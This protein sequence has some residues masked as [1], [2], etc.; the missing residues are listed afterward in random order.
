MFVEQFFEY[1]NDY[2]KIFC[3]FQNYSNTQNNLNNK[4][5]LSDILSII[6]KTYF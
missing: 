3:C 5:Y 1:L 6:A 4:Q 2:A